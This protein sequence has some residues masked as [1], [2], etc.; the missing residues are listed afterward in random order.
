MEHLAEQRE[1]ASVYYMLRHSYGD[2]LFPEH[3]S[4][5]P[6]SFLQIGM[7]NSWGGYVLTHAD[8]IIH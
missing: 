2:N 8:Y 7:L 5:D 6:A 3:E 1:L 4:E